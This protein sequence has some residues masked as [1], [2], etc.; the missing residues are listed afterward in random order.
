MTV[1]KHILHTPP[2][3]VIYLQFDDHESDD[4]T[5]AE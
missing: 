4:E 2:K 1:I 5:D 3:I